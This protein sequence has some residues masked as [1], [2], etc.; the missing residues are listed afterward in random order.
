MA[1]KNRSTS[2]FHHLLNTSLIVSPAAALADSELFPHQQWFCKATAAGGWACEEQDA[3]PGVYP[4]PK[5]M[6][7]IETDRYKKTAKT[8]KSIRAA[9]A[10]GGNP[11]WDWQPK[12]Q[13]EDPTACR[14]GCDGTFVEPAANWPDADQHPDEA[15]LRA[16][17]QQS[18]TEGDV[19]TLQGDVRISQG[20]QMIKA[21]DAV[22]NR[23]KNELQLSGN[24]EIR[25]PKQLI[26]GESAHIDTETNLGVIQQARFVKHDAHFHGTAKQAERIAEQVIALDD[27]MFSQCVPEDQDWVMKSSSM[28]LNSE[29]GRGVA[30]HAKLYVGDIP[31]LYTPYISF[32]IDDRRATG[33]LFPTLGS[34]SSGFDLTTPYYLN[35]APN[36]DATLAP[37]YIADRGFMAETEFRYLS[38]YD[39]WELSGSH[40][41]SDDVTG[42]DRW[43]A[44]VEEDGRFGTNWSTKIDYTKVSDDEFFDDFTLNSIDARRQT[45]LLQQASLSYGS[46]NWLSTLRVVDYQTIDDNDEPYKRLPQLTISNRGKPGNFAPDFLFTGEFTEFDI[47]DDTEETGQRLYTEAGISYPMRWAPG[48]VIPT[49]KVRHLDYDLDRVNNNQ[50]DAPSTTVPLATL[51]M[52]LIFERNTQFF[53]SGSYLQTLEPRLYYFYSDYE[54]QD[55]NPDFDTTRLTFTYQQLFRDTRFSGHDLLDDA[56][57]LSLGVTTRYINNRSGDEI[58][59]AS[60]GQIFYFEDRRIE[61]EDTQD[62]ITSQNQL[63]NSNIAGG[64]QFQ[65][66][67]QFWTTTDLLWDSR[68]NNLNEAGVGMHYRSDANAIYNLGSRYRRAG[69]TNSGS[70]TRDLKNIDGSMALPFAEQWSLF[71]RYQYDLEENRS[72][73]ELFGLEYNS[74]CWTGRI[75][76]QRAITDEDEVNPNNIERDNIVVFEFQL[77]GM[78]SLGSTTKSLLEESILGYQQQ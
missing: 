13:L 15:P 43:L 17:S 48:F 32:P 30:K 70:D 28:V 18:I 4:K 44:S 71:A 21:D 26:R 40:L 45:H 41:S 60:I 34:G 20:H 42:E 8:E 56:N 72:A 68:Q 73:E 29:T 54:N 39:M 58:L 61:A 23:S 31:I 47:D 59:S 75:V 14:T 77:K 16:E 6:A 66:H 74:C 11:D 51:D 37:R 33:F 57:Q 3:A 7:P 62:E 78:G 67:Q 1:S 10:T 25:Q 55:G 12:Q 5:V 9:L 50:N 38:P 52:G 19:I 46:Q 53:G 69:A 22:L 76:Y 36:Y 64:L 63:S 27:A 35:L 24:I 65:P 2:L 49:V